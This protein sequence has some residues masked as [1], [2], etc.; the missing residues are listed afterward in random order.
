MD[1]A[2]WA[3]SAVE[4]VFGSNSQLHGAIAEVYACAN[5]Q[6]SF[7]GDVVAA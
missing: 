3:G 2:K 6:H 4:V 7:V 1:E 5:S